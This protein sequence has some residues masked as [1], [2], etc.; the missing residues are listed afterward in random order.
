M[1]PLVRALKDQ[2]L[3]IRTSSAMALDILSWNLADVTE[4]VYYLFAKMF[5]NMEGIL[6]KDWDEI[7]GFGSQAAEPLIQSLHVEDQVLLRTVKNTYS[8]RIRQWHNSVGY[9]AL[10]A[11]VEIGKPVVEPLTEALKDNNPTIRNIQQL[12]SAR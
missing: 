11:L 2:K 12:F 5:I 8:G 3:G 4:R 7:I 6:Q 1:E 9:I 10:N